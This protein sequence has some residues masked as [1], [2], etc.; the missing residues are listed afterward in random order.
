MCI[1]RGAKVGK[2]TALASLHLPRQIVQGFL[3]DMDKGQREQGK[4]IDGLPLL[5]TAKARC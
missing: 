2:S 4:I 3:K 1:E 5:P